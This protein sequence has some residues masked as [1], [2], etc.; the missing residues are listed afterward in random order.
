MNFRKQKT[1]EATHLPTTTVAGTVY[2][3]Q[4]P[5]YAQVP[6]DANNPHV[7]TWAKVSKGIPW[8]KVG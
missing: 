1:L 4:N 7:K 3:G 8:V 6:I 5:Q 2:K